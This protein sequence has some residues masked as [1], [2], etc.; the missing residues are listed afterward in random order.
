MPA[1]DEQQ[2]H[3]HGSTSDSIS[4]RTEQNMPVYPWEGHGNAFAT[5]APAAMA[6]WPC[7][8][9][10]MK[11]YILDPR[12]SQVIYLVTAIVAAAGV[13]PT[14]VDDSSQHLGGE[15]AGVHGVDRVD[16]SWAYQAGS[17]GR[18]LCYRVEGARIAGTES[19]TSILDRAG[20]VEAGGCTGFKVVP[21]WDSDFSSRGIEQTGSG[22]VSHSR[23]GAESMSQM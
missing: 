21:Y 18:R 12:S 22:Q 14:P 23:V 6:G 15:S 11:A 7:S 5:A 10:W 3:G 17:A 13:L 16:M 8:Y 19:S 4:L 1:T 20:A 9:Y 2:A